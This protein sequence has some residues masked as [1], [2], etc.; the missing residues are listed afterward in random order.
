[1]EQYGDYLLRTAFLL[2][3]DR[4]AA[5]EAVQD[6]F[7]TAY[8]KIGQLQNPLKLRSWLTRIVVNRCRMRQRTW[9]WRRLF[10]FPRMEQLLEDGSEPG[11]EERLLQGL[12]SER[13]TDAIQQLAYPYREAIT[14]YYFNE[15]NIEE[16]SEQLGCNKNTVKARLARG[17]ARLKRIL[18]EGADYSGDS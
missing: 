14:L 12:R 10:A 8:Y 3:K 7:V 4:H 18:E 1:M 9:D 13:L 2:V 17:R 5:E 11:P 16:I 6:T 15:M